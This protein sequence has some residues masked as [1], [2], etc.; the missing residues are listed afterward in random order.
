MADTTL[1]LYTSLTAGSSHIITATSR[2]E[3]ILKAN[4]IPFQAIDVATDDAA[5][6]LW[7]RYSKGRKLP[8]LV[9]YKTIIGDLEQIEEWNEY[10]ELK[11]E[12]G[13]IKDPND[14]SSDS[15][16]KEVEVPKPAPVATTTNKSSEPSA[17]RVQIQNP[18]VNENKEDQR[19]LALRLAGEEAAAKAKDNARSKLGSKPA[20]TEADGKAPTSGPETKGT[21][22][23]V[24]LR[25][26]DEEEKKP[27]ESF[28]SDNR[29]KT[30]TKDSVS[31]STPTSSPAG[32]RSSVV[33][34][35]IPPSQL[36][37][38][39]LADEVA[40]VSSA[41]FHADN[42]ELLG[43]VG[44]HR[45]SII[46]ATTEDEQEKVRK[47]IRASISEAPAD[48]DI[49]ALRKTAVER[50]GDT[51]FED[52]EESEEKEEKSVVPAAREEKQEDT[53]NQD[54]MDASKAGVS[55]AD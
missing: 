13:A 9:K 34:E 18:P 4:K 32:R 47:D 39:S 28:T 43:L 31:H 33:P 22:S 15:Q 16:K 14:F 29:E 17:P 25:Q 30:T 11:A 46:S 5:R 52:E 8:G 41:N 2:L 53:K 44:H 7:G 40:A 42:A 21:E 48:G 1:Y 38:P 12:I 23:A 19:T 26:K 49:D 54:P 6:R 36:K 20:T 55:V 35:I 3:T 24:V 45:G 27:N 37:R 51:I 50:E 10:G